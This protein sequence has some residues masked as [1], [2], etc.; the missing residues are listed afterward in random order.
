M[1]E[2]VTSLNTKKHNQLDSYLVIP[3]IRYLI[4]LRKWLIMR[5]KNINLKH[6]P[7]LEKHKIPFLKKLPLVGSKK[8]IQKT[9]LNEHVYF[10]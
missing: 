8:S 7:T 1:F 4:R 2:K 10:A 5:E 9:E 6:T 3:N